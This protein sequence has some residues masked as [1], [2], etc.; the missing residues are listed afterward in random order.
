MSE[1]D[2]DKGLFCNSTPFLAHIT[3]LYG[4]WSDGT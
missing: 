3:D 1:P 4:R 2:L